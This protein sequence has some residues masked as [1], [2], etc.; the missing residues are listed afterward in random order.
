MIDMTQ[1]QTIYGGT[2]DPVHYSHL[3]LVET[4]VNQIDLSKV[5]IMPSSAPPHRPQPEAI[6]AQHMHVLKLTIADKPL[7]TFDECELQRDTPSWITD[8][9]QA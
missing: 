4:L 6:S 1:S 5:I 8:T 9:L 3:K 2:F 7:F